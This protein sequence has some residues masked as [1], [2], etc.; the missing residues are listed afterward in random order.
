MKMYSFRFDVYVKLSSFHPPCHQ[1]NWSEKEWKILKNA[2]KKIN[3]WK[4]ILAKIGGED[5][6]NLLK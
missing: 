6:H 3:E 1:N 2:E 4:F 5:I